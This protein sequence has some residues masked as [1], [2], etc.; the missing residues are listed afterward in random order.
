[1]FQFAR[2]LLRDLAA[3]TARRAFQSLAATGPQVAFLR[4]S[5]AKM[6]GNLEAA[7][8]TA[9]ALGHEPGASQGARKKEEGGRDAAVRVQGVAPELGAK[10]GAREQERNADLCMQGVCRCVRAV[11]VF[12]PLKLDAYACVRC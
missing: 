3:Q 6:A 12:A 5:A 9:R 7:A 4:R 2:G 1:M 10:Q 11:A 8:A